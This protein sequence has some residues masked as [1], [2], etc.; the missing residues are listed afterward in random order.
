VMN[1][2]LAVQRVRCSMMLLKQQCNRI[3]YSKE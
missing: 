2:L 3:F 1:L